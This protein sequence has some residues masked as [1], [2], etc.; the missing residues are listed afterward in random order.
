MTTKISG[1]GRW[2]WIEA[3]PSYTMIYLFNT[4]EEAEHVMKR[5]YNT[6]PCHDDKSFCLWCSHQTK[7]K[8][9]D[10]IDDIKVNIT[11][12]YET[13]KPIVEIL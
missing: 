4:K 6:M 5:V 12:P 11:I 10:S 1:M 3:C 7:L 9:I 2:A 13:I 8:E